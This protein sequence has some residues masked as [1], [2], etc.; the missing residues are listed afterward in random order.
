MKQTRDAF[1]PRSPEEERELRAVVALL[2]GLPDPEPPE[3]LCAQV[4]AE[5][6]R[7]ESGPRVL[8]VAFR[9]FEPLIATA[10]AA[11][12]GALVLTTAMQSGLIPSPG[13]NVASPEPAPLRPTAAR[14]VA[15]AHPSGH[16][17]VRPR[18]AP[19]Y[20]GL[21]GADLHTAHLRDARATLPFTG[22]GI[23]LRSSSTS[24]LDRRLD[25][26]LNSLLL[27]PVSFYARVQQMEQPDQFMA[28]LVDRATRRGDAAQ[29]AL[30]LRVRSPEH[31]T[32]D[33]LV[34]RLLSAA[35]SNDPHR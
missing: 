10:V 12:V 35:M 32:T 31:P 20:V 4:M 8:R 14:R 16:D 2:R 5:V 13:S 24:P 27:D 22:G 29:V 23:D 19:I 11:G 30:R 25:R 6:R 17:H 15:D 33:A 3:A 26:D 21:P 7:R 28:R 34:D 18:I 1:E 9:R